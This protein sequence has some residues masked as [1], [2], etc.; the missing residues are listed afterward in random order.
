TKATQR[1]KG[2]I[3]TQSTR[4]VNRNLKKVVTCHPQS[5]NT[6]MSTYTG[7]IIPLPLKVTKIIPHW[8]PWKSTYKPTILSSFT[9]TSVIREEGENASIRRKCLHKV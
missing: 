3:S 4:E 8:H 1:I 6:E 9:S 5:G 7:L 2:L